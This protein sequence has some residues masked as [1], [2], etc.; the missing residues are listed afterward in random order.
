MAAR[1][2]QPTEPCGTAAAY[3]RHL[4]HGEPP[5]DECILADRERQADRRNGEMGTLSSDNRLIRNGL[6]H[7]KPY[8]YPGSK[9]MA[10]MA[11]DAG[12]QS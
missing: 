5:C 12:A 11:A 7:F 6:P 1:G 9:F 2:P 8:I 10:R 3:R 4:R